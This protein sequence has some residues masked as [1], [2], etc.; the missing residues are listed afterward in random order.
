MPAKAIAAKIV[1]D[2]LT[3]VVKPLNWEALEALKDDIVNMQEHKANFFEKE[4]RDAMMR[5]VHVSLKRT[6]PDLDEQV[7]RNGLDMNNAAA[8]IQT[9]M[10]VSGFAEGGGEPAEGELAADGLKI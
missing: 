8:V 1:L 9:V 4:V 3:Y 10:G 5:I 7:V 2:G 6:Y